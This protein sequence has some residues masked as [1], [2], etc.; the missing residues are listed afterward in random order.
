MRR[1]LVAAGEASG[2]LHAARAVA[3]L[4]TRI[5][6]LEVFGLGGDELAGAGAELLAHSR[7]IAV[8]GIVEVL[9]VLSQARRTFASLVEAA[10]TRRPDAALLV[11]FPEFNLRLAKQLAALG[12]PVV[13]YV[14][15]Q[16][17]AWR[18]GRVEQ[19]R[20]RVDRMLVLFPFEVEFYRRHGIEAVHVGHPLVDEVPRLPQAW[21]RP[22]APDEPLRLALLPGSR[23]SEL[24]P[25]LPR[26]LEAATRLAADR[27]LAVRLIRAA[28]IDRGELE[29]V[30]ADFP[31]PV[32]IVEQRRFEAIADSHLA[33]CASGTATLE[34]GL[35][36]TPL[37]V[38]YRLAPWSYWL[39][40]ALVR[41]PYYTLIN[42]VLDDAVVPELI[43]GQSSGEHLARIAGQLL[44][45]P[46]RI[47][48]MRAR[49]AQLRERLGPPG[50]SGQVAAALAEVL[51]GRT[52]RAEQAG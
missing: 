52:T 26:M 7:E 25:L 27:P 19:V 17:W 45:D 6:D 15:P 47:A 24:G 39:G 34:V 2:D 40:R 44:D 22:R 18:S 10:R 30:L 29:A 8:V 13:Y 9:K 37:V 12:I 14:S 1:L 21:D 33:L 36:G 42:L 41:L 23:R 3:D 5:P 32:E 28:T 51:E 50:A 46:A 16:L 43:Q 11:D 20:R 35:L 49:L 31:L 38:A 4:R 48:S